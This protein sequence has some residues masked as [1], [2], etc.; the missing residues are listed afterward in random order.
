M[1]V[2]DINDTL[3][4]IEIAI[5]IKA[6]VESLAYQTK[7]VINAMIE[8]SGKEIVRLKVDGGASANNYLMQFQ[9]DILDVIVDRPKMIEVTA[10]GAALLAGIKAGIWKKEQIETI[11]EINTLFHSTMKSKERKKKYKGW[12]NAVKR[13]KSKKR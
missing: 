8:D 5:N 12:L 10:F 9:S 3:D 6:T 1:L 4:T 7:D 13:T 11:R 2:R